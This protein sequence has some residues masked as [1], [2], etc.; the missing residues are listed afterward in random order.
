MEVLADSDHDSGGGR[1]RY[2]IM[3]DGDKTHGVNPE[4]TTLGTGTS[5]DH[6]ISHRSTASSPPPPPPRDDRTDKSGA[7]SAGR[8][9]PS[10]AS[11]ELVGA[12]QSELLLSGAQGQE[13]QSQLCL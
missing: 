1:E 2:R 4:T 3:E 9:N 8:H 6:G 10:A 12:V 11:G 13:S 7:D 5:Q